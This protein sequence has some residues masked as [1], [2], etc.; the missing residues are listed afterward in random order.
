MKK[1]PILVI[2]GPTA[3]GK[4]DLAVQIALNIED[5]SRGHY[6]GAEIISADS[7]QVYKGLDIGTGK[8]T[9]KEM[10]GVKHHLLDV[11]EPTKVFDVVQFKKLAEDSINRIF[12]RGNLPIICGGTGFYIDAI[13]YNID[14]AN[15]KADKKLRNKLCKLSPT[16]LFAML[17]KIDPIRAAKMNTSDNKNPVRLIRAIEIAKGLALSK[18]ATKIATPISQETPIYEPI[19]IGLQLD[20]ET[21][22][23]RI[24]DRLIKR[25]DNGMIEEAIKLHKQTKDGGSNLTWKRM[26]QLGLEYRYLARLL[27]KKISKEDMT[28]SLNTEIMRYAKRQI[29][30]FKRNTKINWF[31]PDQKVEI[32]EF[33]KIH[34]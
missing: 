12:N 13:I 17:Q 8:I 3:T 31:R 29:T 6:N 22:A 23:K 27:Q 16:K 15:I 7:R 14:F 25:I 20:R 24:N 2:L 4:S 5:L 26:E 34:L 1:I 11:C 28:N 19:F 30:W 33:L 32:L 18:Q 9:E 21:L 10:K